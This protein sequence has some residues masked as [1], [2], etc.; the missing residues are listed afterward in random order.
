MHFHKLTWFLFFINDDSSSKP[1]LRHL[2]FDLWAM[3]SEVAT[4]CTDPHRCSGWVS[5]LDVLPE[6][7]LYL[8]LAGDRDRDIQT[9]APVTTLLRSGMKGHNVSGPPLHKAHRTPGKQILVSSLHTAT[10]P[11]KWRH[12]SAMK[13]IYIKRSFSWVI[14]IL[15]WSHLEVKHF[16]VRFFSF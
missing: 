6:M 8:I 11:L 9:W 4:A 16:C 7:I 1:E 10:E 2:V 13:M 5:V 12:L 15:S 14:R 3:P